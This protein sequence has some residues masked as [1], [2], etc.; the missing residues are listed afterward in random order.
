MC[1]SVFQIHEFISEGTEEADCYKLL[2][3]VKVAADGTNAQV[4]ESETVKEMGEFI[5]AIH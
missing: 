1:F 5:N 2:P 3:N 4:V